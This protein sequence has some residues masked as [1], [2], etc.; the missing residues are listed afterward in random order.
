M[1]LD[2]GMDMLLWM[3]VGWFL[4]SHESR[5]DDLLCPMDV[6]RKVT[7]VLA[8]MEFSLQLFG[9]NGGVA[10]PFFIDVGCMGVDMMW[11]RLSVGLS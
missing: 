9:S 3:E 2:D 1:Y 4:S 8:D 6:A 11:R 5:R 7:L 10:E